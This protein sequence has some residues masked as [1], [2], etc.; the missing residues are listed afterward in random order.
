MKVKNLIALALLL[1]VITK[2]AF[3]QVPKRD[4]VK[5]LIDTTVDI[6]K[7]KS[8]Y[9]DGVNWE[10]VRQTAL[11]K[12]VGIT[13][14]YN[15][16][17]VIRFLLKSANEFHGEFHY[18]DSIFRWNGKPV[19]TSDSTAKEI[20]N[21]VIRTRLLPNKTGYVKLSSMWG[22]DKKTFDVLAQKLNDSLCNVLKPDTKGIIID[23][24]TDDGGS[25]YPMILGLRQLL[26]Q[27]K[28]GAFYIKGQKTNSI[29]YLK[30]NNFL[31]DTT[32]FA[33]IVPKCKLDGQKLPVVILIGPGTGSS[34]EFTAIA[35]K[36]RP[37]TLF[38]GEPTAG[39]DTS[40]INFP[41]NKRASI[42]VTVGSGLDR[43]NIPYDGPIKP[44]VIVKGVDSYNNL[45]KD[46][47]IKAAIDWLKKQR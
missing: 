35:F 19:A 37:K 1:T 18:R 10:E 33:S 32:T 8:L 34:G 46:D 39:Y 21:R 16:G 22:P 17:D 36:G 2:Q 14:P 42:N 23:L 4:E 31:V 44:D 38:I 30:E 13:N 45:L 24:R 27:G 43:N 3:S 29:W 28:L 47:K 12:A 9:A 5:F 11:Q 20:N 40:P 41:I 6:L 7:K 15:M 25:M 26:D